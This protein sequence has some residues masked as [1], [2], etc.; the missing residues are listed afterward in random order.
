MRQ[1]K[2]RAL[3]TLDPPAPGREVRQYPSGTHALM[4]HAWQIDD[5]SHDKYFP[6]VILPDTEEPLRQGERVVATVTVDGDDALA[7]LGAGQPFTIWGE[8]G[9]HGVISRRVFT[10]GAPC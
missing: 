10:D 5:L 3:L 4:I 6:T 8:C 2:F 1:F 9:G 7:Y